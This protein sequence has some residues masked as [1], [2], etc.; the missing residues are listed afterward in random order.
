MKGLQRRSESVWQALGLWLVHGRPCRSLSEGLRN[1]HLNL[2]LA[3]P[4]L[5]TPFTLSTPRLWRI[6]SRP[7]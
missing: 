3:V 7:R 2:D 1:P 6:L 4:S 5:L